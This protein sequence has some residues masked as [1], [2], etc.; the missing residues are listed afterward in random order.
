MTLPNEMESEAEKIRAELGQRYRLSPAQLAALPTIESLD[1][2]ASI[3]VGEILPL[4]FESMMS[5]EDIEWMENGPK[6]DNLPDILN[7][8][9][10]PR[11]IEM[12]ED[13][14]NQNEIM[15][16]LGGFHI[17]F[18]FSLSDPFAS[19][20]A[21]EANRDAQNRRLSLLQNYESLCV[22]IIE[23][24][25]QVIDQK[26]VAGRFLSIY[27]PM[28]P[29][30]SPSRPSKAVKQTRRSGP[31]SNGTSLGNGE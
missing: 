23:G 15:N 13:Q 25:N 11:I 24:R 26:S 7:E 1:E 22:K 2:V 9:R 31:K 18:I 29:D 3:C 27:F 4:F 14:R 30:G 20:D 5:P 10:P 6:S 19:E 8:L 28:P 21:Q 17:N 16:A 12:N